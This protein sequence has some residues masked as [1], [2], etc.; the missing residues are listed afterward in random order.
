MAYFNILSQSFLLYRRVISAYS[1]G[2]AAPVAGVEAVLKTI[3][4]PNSEQSCSRSVG[5]FVA[6]LESK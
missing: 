3:L 4:R 1:V 5:G 6:F 2:E